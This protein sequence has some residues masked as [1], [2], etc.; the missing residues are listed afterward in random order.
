MNDS[1]STS[2]PIDVEFEIIEKSGEPALPITMYGAHSRFI[3]WPRIYTIRISGDLMH[4]EGPF[5][6]DLPNATDEYV[7]SQ[8]IAPKWIDV[9]S[10][11]IRFRIPGRGKWA[12]DISKTPDRELTVS[13]IRAWLKNIEGK[14]ATEFITSELRREIFRLPVIYSFAQFLVILLGVL[15]GLVF[16]EINSLSLLVNGSILLL[17]GL[18]FHQIGLKTTIFGLILG[19]LLNCG[20]LFMPLIETY[21]IGQVETAKFPLFTPFCFSPGAIIIPLAIYSYIYAIFEFPRQNGRILH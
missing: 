17:F 5:Q 12:I 14:E 2:E 19:F 6:D 15:F 10:R 7:F 20:L 18:S 13:R 21:L 8:S 16:E 1:L 4:I 9:R 3:G 11:S